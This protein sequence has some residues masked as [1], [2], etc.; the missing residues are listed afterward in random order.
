MLITF[1]NIL[2]P[3]LECGLHKGRDFC[4]WP[5]CY[6]KCLEQPLA[7]SSTQMF[8]D[9]TMW[10]M[11]SETQW[12]GIWNKSSLG[13]VGRLQVLSETGE[14]LQDSRQSSAVTWQKFK[15]HRSGCCIED[16]LWW[17]G[18]KVKRHLWSKYSNWMRN[19][20]GTD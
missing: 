7:P 6:F 8:T 3:S 16:G 18:V 20:K 13:F 10:Q 1:P 17:A 4:F 12:D 15:K 9:K 5:L 19:H 2:P 11:R 14:P